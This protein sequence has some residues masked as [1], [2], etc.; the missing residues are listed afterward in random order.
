MSKN[1][2][3]PDGGYGFDGAGFAIDKASQLGNF[4]GQH[5]KNQATQHFATGEQKA[6]AK[7]AQELDRSGMNGNTLRGIQAGTEALTMMGAKPEF[8]EFVERGRR[9]RYDERMKRTQGD[10]LERAGITTSDSSGFTPMVSPAKRARESEA[11]RMAQ[12]YG[13][14]EMRLALMDKAP[15]D[16]RLVDYYGAQARGAQSLSGEMAKYFTESGRFENE[17]QANQFIQQHA[18]VAFREYTKANPQAVI[19]E[20]QKAAFSL[21]E[22]EAIQDTMDQGGLS[23]E[24]AIRQIQQGTAALMGEPQGTDRLQ[25]N[26]AEMDGTIDLEG[27]TRN[28]EQNQANAFGPL[29]EASTNQAIKTDE[30]VG[31]QGMQPQSA[32]IAAENLGQ[33]SASPF[34]SANKEEINRLGINAAVDPGLM[35]SLVSQRLRQ[36]LAS[37]KGNK[38][39]S[40]DA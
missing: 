33:L 34:Y 25:S 29:R 20:G 4:L 8:V 26:E 9:A 24:D 38:G 11:Q 18:G 28:R 35:D 39:F 36:Q 22:P 17:A 13:G 40:Y 7:K 30:G 1:Y 37:I 32:A 10:I 5:L 15:I 23:R 6:A 3:H 16:Q 27:G 14:N 19:G 21:I 12:Q 31:V 2:S